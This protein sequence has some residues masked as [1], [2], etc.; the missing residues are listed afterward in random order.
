MVSLPIPQRR[1]GVTYSDLQLDDQLSYLDVMLQLGIGKLRRRAKNVALDERTEVHLDPDLVRDV[2]P[3]LQ[4]WRAVYGQVNA[5]LTHLKTQAVAPGDIFL[6]FGWFRPTILTE[7]GYRYVGPGDGF[8]A[9]FGYLQVGELLQ[10]DLRQPTNL[11]NSI[12]KLLLGAA[13]DEPPPYGFFAAAAWSSLM[14]SVQ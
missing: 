1:S 14:C 3:R 4:G 9:V 10:V 5:A 11:R 13:G 6:F 2:R 8:H 12:R 7:R